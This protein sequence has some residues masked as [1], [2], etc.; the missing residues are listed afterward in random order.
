MVRVCWSTHKNPWPTYQEGQEQWRQTWLSR[1]RFL[2]PK[3]AVWLSRLATEFETSGGLFVESA[4]CAN[5]HSGNMRC[6]ESRHW[7]AVAALL[8]L[9][10]P[11]AQLCP[12]ST[13][14]SFVPSRLF[15]YLPILFQPRVSTAS[16]LNPTGRS[17]GS[18]PE[19]RGKC[20]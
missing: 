14:S 5:Y 11:G 13:V 10:M 1:L 15:C 8:C 17:R 20:I 3:L 19:Q 9:V 6:A 2:V 18:T 4:H 12:G 7:Y 16:T